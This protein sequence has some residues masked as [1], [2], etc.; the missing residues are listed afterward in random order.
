[1]NIA[2][3]MDTL[4]VSKIASAV[5]TDKPVCMK[6]LGTTHIPFLK[7]HVEPVFSIFSEVLA[8]VLSFENLCSIYIAWNLSKNVKRHCSLDNQL[9]KKQQSKAFMV[10]KLRRDY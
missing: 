7:H 1:M 3:M 5:R 8:D 10:F 4:G 2:S 6:N 9:W